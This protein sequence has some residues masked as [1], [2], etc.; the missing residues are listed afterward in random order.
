MIKVRNMMKQYNWKR[1]KVVKLWCGAV[2]RVTGIT[3]I[4]RGGVAKCVDRGLGKR[5]KREGK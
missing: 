1:G 4:V 2:T 3:D 5:G